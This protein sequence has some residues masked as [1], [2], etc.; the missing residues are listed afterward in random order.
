MAGVA[1]HRPVGAAERPV[2]DRDE[3]R[4]APGLEAAHAR[5]GL[6]DRVPAEAL[7]DAA[8]RLEALARV[9][10]SARRARARAGSGCGASRRRR[11]ARRARRRRARATG[12][13]RSAR[14][15]RGSSPG[16]SSMSPSS[17]ITCVYSRQSPA[18]A[19]PALKVRGAAAR[20]SRSRTGLRQR[21]GLDDGRGT[22]PRASSRRRISSV[23]SSEPSST[24][25]QRAGGSSWAATAR[26]TRS[27]CAASL[28]TGEM[29][30]MRGSTPDSNAPARL[31]LPRSIMRPAPAPGRRRTRGA[32]ARASAATRSAWRRRRRRRRGGR[33]ARGRRPARSSR[34]RACRVEQ[35]LARPALQVAR[36]ASSTAAPRSPASGGRGCRRAASARSASRRIHFFSPPRTLSSAGIEAASSISSWSSSGER[37]SSACAIVAMS[38]FAIRSSAR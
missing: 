20:A 11:S 27:M 36:A 6:V 13:R 4:E 7:L 16:C 14:S 12:R 2:V 32:T 26:T 17:F 31:G 25:I 21:A 35:D 8:D 15:A 3:V 34:G 37:A 22:A 33:A 19:R 5:V 24:T 23:S 28:R 1:A 29:M 30:R 18:A 10:A 38:I 9:A